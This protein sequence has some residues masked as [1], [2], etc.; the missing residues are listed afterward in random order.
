[1]TDSQPD[2]PEDDQQE[3][4]RPGDTGESTLPDLTDIET[5][6]TTDPLDGMFEWGEMP[7][8]TADDED[9]DEGS[10]TQPPNPLR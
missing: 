10:S 5:V 6:Q 8:S 9:Q 2:K 1:M 4:F 7:G 3:E